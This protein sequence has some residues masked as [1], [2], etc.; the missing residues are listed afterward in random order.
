MIRIRTLQRKHAFFRN[1]LAN[2][3]DRWYIPREQQ[4]G[5]S[6]Y[7]SII[8]KLMDLPAVQE[9]SPFPPSSFV[10]QEVATLHQKRVA[11]MQSQPS[12]SLNSEIG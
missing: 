8:A 10:A 1:L 4:V 7:Q 3:L 9:G 6:V 12:L 2:S 5:R 11:L